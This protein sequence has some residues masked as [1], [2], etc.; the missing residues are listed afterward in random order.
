MMHTVTRL[1]TLPANCN[2]SG[3]PPLDVSAIII[4]VN[5]LDVIIATTLPTGTV[6]LPSTFPCGANCSLVST[7]HTLEHLRYVNV[8][9]G[10]GLLHAPPPPGAMTATMAATGAT[11]ALPLPPLLVTPGTQV[12]AGAGAW[13]ISVAVHPGC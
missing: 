7:Q 11:T 4:V 10:L 13:A 3:S 1:Q 9:I 6:S 2:S 12:N 5:V 8:N